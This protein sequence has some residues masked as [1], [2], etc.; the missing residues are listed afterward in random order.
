MAYKIGKF[1][2]ERW[3]AEAERRQ[4]SA[5]SLRGFHDRLLSLGSLPLPAL[6]RE[7]ANGQPSS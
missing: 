4:G 1:Q 6:D 3:R 2:I 7:L 5:F